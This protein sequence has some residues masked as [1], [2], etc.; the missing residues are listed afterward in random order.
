MSFKTSCFPRV[1]QCIL[2]LK[3]LEFVLFS[4]ISF[5]YI[6]KF[7][8]FFFMWKCYKRAYIQKALI[9]LTFISN[10]KSDVFLINRNYLDNL[11]CTR[12][13][14]DVTNIYK[15]GTSVRVKIPKVNQYWRQPEQSFRFIYFMMMFSPGNVYF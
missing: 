10:N 14:C 6:W 8:K 4:I 5:S 2:I 9:F 13:W 1:C 12:W 7:V 11:P 3:L 15:K